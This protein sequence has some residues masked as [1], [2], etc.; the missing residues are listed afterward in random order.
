MDSPVELDVVSRQYHFPLGPHFFKSVNHSSVRQQ[1]STSQRPKLHQA[2]AT[3]AAPHHGWSLISREWCLLI[4]ESVVR[5]E[6]RR[7]V[8]RI[9]AVVG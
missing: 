5:Y 4:E 7:G 2:A 8:K 1:R 3:G 6:F 9:R